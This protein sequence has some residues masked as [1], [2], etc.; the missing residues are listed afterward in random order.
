MTERA[1][2]LQAPTSSA[3]IKRFSNAV[4]VGIVIAAMSF[5]N[6]SDVTKTYHDEN[7]WK[8]VVNGDDYFI[9]G[10][11]WGYSPPGKNHSYNLWGEPDD[12]IRKVLDYEFSLLRAAGINTIRSFNFMPPQW[13]TYVYREYG[14]MSVINPLMGRYGATIDGEWVPYVD[15]SDELTRATLKEEALEVVRQYK[16]VPGVMMFAFGNE[17]NYGLSWSSF[18]IENLP[19]G[20][21]DTA[22]ARYLYSLFE[23][24]VAAGKEIAPDKVFTIVNGD[25]QYIDL[26]AELVPSLDLLGSNVYRGPSFTGLWR[27]VAEKLDLPV[28]LFEFGSDAFNASESR[29]DQFAQAKLLREQWQELYNKAYGYGEEGNSVGGF[30]FEWRDEWW[31]YLQDRNLSVHDTHASWANQGYLFDW[32]DGQNNMNEEWFGIAAIGPRN[33][34]GVYTARTRQA[35]DVLSKIWAMDPYVD[36]K[37]DFNAA[38]DSIDMDYDAAPPEAN[39][40]LPLV[41]YEN[42]F[43]GMPWVPSGLMGNVSSLKLDGNHREEGRENDPIIRIRYMAKGGWVGVAW[44]HPPENWGEQPDGIDLTGATALELLARGKYGGEQVSFAVGMLDEGRDY[45]DSAI[46]KTAPISL[47]SE[48]KRFRLSLEGEDLSSLKTG[49]V[50]TLQ[51]RRSPVTFYLD[52]IRFVR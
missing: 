52:D 46:V 20:E 19:E 18:E 33:D 35:Y 10:I 36:N 48:W 21:Q 44:Q 45:P 5:A 23:E 51:G 11:V 9:K 3:L 40:L 6:A 43:D 17:S 41:V 27:D 29:E 13:V 14:I 16:D 30:V 31:K 25:I 4:L 24:V 2:A 49:F 26:I 32:A 8:L 28:V 1:I 38:V 34:D 50:V 42:G 37:S 22:K 47:T 7:G 12:F 15:Y 39:P